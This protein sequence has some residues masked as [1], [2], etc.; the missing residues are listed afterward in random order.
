MVSRFRHG[1]RRRPIRG[2]A[3]V[4]LAI[5]MPILALLLVMAIDFGRAFYTYIAVG[6][7]AREGAAYAAQ[8][9]ADIGGVQV[10]ARAE[11]GL[12]PGDPS[13]TVVRICTPDPCSG[14]I[15][16][17]VAGQHDVTVRV[18]ARVDLITPLASS[19][20]GRLELE[21]DATAVIP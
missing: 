1:D 21:R 2:Q 15:G 18:T 8:H 10:Q 19:I 9:P 6:N 3:L 7:A 14:S 11:M 12:P 13:V 20:V 5:V 4:E 17:S 16:T